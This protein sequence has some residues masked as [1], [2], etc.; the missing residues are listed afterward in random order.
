MCVSCV[1]AYVCLS[2]C[3]SVVIVRYV[4]VDD[5]VLKFPGALPLA[6]GARPTGAPADWSEAD[7]ALRE[8][9]GLGGGWSDEMDGDEGGC[10]GSPTVASAAGAEGGGGGGGGGGG[11]GS[12]SVSMEALLRLDGLRE[13]SVARAE[14]ATVKLTTTEHRTVCTLYCG[15]HVSYEHS[16][17]CER[18]RE[19]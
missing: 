12:N 7:R 3:I 5:F 14:A 17:V 4:Y 18:K 16:W 11:P 10:V 1:C 6:P 8:L 9:E 19:H 2:R 15:R 13:E